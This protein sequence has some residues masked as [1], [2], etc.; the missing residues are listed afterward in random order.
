MDVHQMPSKWLARLVMH[1]A[2]LNRCWVT[3]KLKN[4]KMENQVVPIHSFYKICDGVLSAALSANEEQQLFSALDPR[5]TG[6]VSWEEFR[7]SI[8]PVVYPPALEGGMSLPASEAAPCIQDGPRGRQGHFIYD[9]PVVFNNKYRQTLDESG[10]PL[11]QNI[12]KSRFEHTD[13]PQWSGGD[14]EPEGSLQ[15]V[16][17]RPAGKR[18]NGRGPSYLEF[19]KRSGN[20]MIQSV[21]QASSAAILRTMCSF[22]AGVVVAQRMD[23]KLVFLI[24]LSIYIRLYAVTGLRSATQSRCLLLNVMH[25]HPKVAE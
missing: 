8:W 3:I 15:V 9:V 25:D 13:H 12:F 4:P 18:T 7:E 19:D 5:G 14:I 21:L 24:Y 11:L 22:F 6:F 1:Y 10:R 2:R 23:S 17:H 20:P 16:P